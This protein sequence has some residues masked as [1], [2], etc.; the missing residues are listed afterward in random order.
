[1]TLSSVA[2]DESRMARD[3]SCMARVECRMARDES[4]TAGDCCQPDKS[5]HRGVRTDSHLY[6]SLYGLVALLDNIQSSL[7]SIT[8]S[9]ARILHIIPIIIPHLSLSH[10]QLCHHRMNTKLSDPYQA[11]HS[12]IV[13]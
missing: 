5:I 3:E 10:P 12:I 2:R 11:H 7:S 13:S 4:Y 1:M 9:T 8:I 6:L